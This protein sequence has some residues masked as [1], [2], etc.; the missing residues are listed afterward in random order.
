MQAPQKYTSHGAYALKKYVQVVLI[1][2]KVSKEKSGPVG[3]VIL[4]HSMG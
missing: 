4:V 1:A 3:P 2:R